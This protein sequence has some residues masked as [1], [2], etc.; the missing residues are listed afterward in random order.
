MR[1]DDVK[2][3]FL[4]FFI[5]LLISTVVMI[6]I[7]IYLDI[8]NKDKNN[9]N[10]LYEGISTILPKDE[11]ENQTPGEVQNNEVLN[12]ITSAGNQTQ[13]AH[14]NISEEKEDYYYKQLD[15]YSKI[16]YDE[17][18]NNKENLKNGTHKISF[19]KRFDE[20]LKQENGVDALQDYYQ[21]AME[22]FLYD[23]PDVFYLDPTKMY[24]NIQTTKKIFTTTYEVFIDSGENSNYLADGYNSKEQILEFE[25]KIKEEV[26]KILAKTEGKNKYQ[27]IQAVHD[28]L[29]D[30]IVY[31]ESLSKENIYNMYGALV[32]KESVC[33]GYAKAFKYLMDKIG[34]ECIVVI[35]S[36]TDA[37]GKTQNHAWNYV[38]FGKE[39]YAID[40]TWDDPIIIGG[41]K[42]SKKHKYKYFLKGIDTMN[43]DHTVS[44]TF[45]DN[46]KVY[47]HPI[48]SA[49]D[50][51]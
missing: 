33:E 3:F 21:S 49:T 34:V 22:T 15:N 40:V 37:E 35:G 38:K 7:N 14:P 18:K 4:I 50:Y 42:A 28:Y 5:L 36:A 26:N 41:G 43:K 39:W 8:M 23:N 12:Q 31:D 48:L 44:N 27:K 24:I 32:N 13:A 6:G 51:Q 16:I 17:L 30:N 20:L 46:G 29:V 11:E 45:V 2:A 47:E 25:N 10:I 19:D 9:L 1:K